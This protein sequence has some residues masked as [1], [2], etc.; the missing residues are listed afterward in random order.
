MR[1]R[2]LVRFF[3]FLAIAS[4]WATIAAAIA[5]NPWFSLDRNALSDLGAVGLPTNYVFNVGI[6][7]AAVLGVIY[8]IYLAASLEGRLAHIGSTVLLI[9]VVHVLLIALFPEGTQPHTTV[10]YEFFIL[11]G[12]AILVI[13]ISLIASGR[14]THGAISAA[15]SIIGFTLTPIIPWPSIGAAEVFAI[16]LMTIW[17]A[18]MLH[19]HIKHQP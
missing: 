6:A 2:G 8:S 12:V 14:K 11:T 3:G 5:V 10:S 17:I 13:G 1:S 4:G 18:T 16:T 19:Y 15:L 9:G 7:V